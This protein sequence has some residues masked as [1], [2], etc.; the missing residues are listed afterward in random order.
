MTVH[1]LNPDHSS[2]ADLALCQ[3][4]GGNPL[5]DGDSACNHL[6][7]VDCGD[8]RMAFHVRS[9][10][11]AIHAALDNAV[12]RYLV[13][14]SDRRGAAAIS[15]DICACAE[16]IDEDTAVIMA[17][18]DGWLDHDINAAA[19]DAAVERRLS[20]GFDRRM[21]AIIYAA[22]DAAVQHRIIDSAITAAILRRKA[23]AAEGQE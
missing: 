12:D 7:T 8:C 10:P 16:D 5:P 23:A 15:A 1:Y 21:Q 11:D 4:N 20:A 13:G 18:I 14:A 2:A 22:V 19:V 9:I 3:G 17:L 6:P